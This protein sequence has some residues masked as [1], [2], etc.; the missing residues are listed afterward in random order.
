MANGDETYPP[1]ILIQ[2]ARRT[3]A[4]MTNLDMQAEGAQKFAQRFGDNNMKAYQQMW[5]KNADSKIFQII[6][7]DLGVSSCR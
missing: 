2:I 7:L 1:K 5:S 6:N 3:Q 4:E